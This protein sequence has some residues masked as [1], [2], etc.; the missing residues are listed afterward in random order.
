MEIFVAVVSLKL[1]GYSTFLT[2]QVVEIGNE[3]DI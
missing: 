3:K 1:E 2:Q